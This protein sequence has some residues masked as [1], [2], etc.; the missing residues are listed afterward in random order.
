MSFRSQCRL[1]SFSLCTLITLFYSLYCGQTEQTNYVTL[2]ALFSAQTPRI[3]IIM[4]KL[5][6]YIMRKSDWRLH[7][8][9]QF[10]LSIIYLTSLLAFPVTLQS[11]TILIYFGLTPIF[12]P[13]W[14]HSWH[15]ALG[16]RPLPRAAS[17]PFQEH[18]FVTGCPSLRRKEWSFPPECGVA[19]TMGLCDDDSGLFCCLPSLM[20]LQAVKQ[21]RESDDGEFQACEGL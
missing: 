16:G 14:K 18:S 5:N 7:H 2:F 4:Q 8:P 3:F 12:P 9:C 1:Y 10:S 19:S 15:R 6:I 20:N 13:L 17:G 11:L 21:V